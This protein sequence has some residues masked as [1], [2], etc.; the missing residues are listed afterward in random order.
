MAHNFL[1]RT[2]SSNREE[3]CEYRC[4]RYP[5]QGARVVCGLWRKGPPFFSFFFFFFLPVYFSVTLFFPCHFVCFES[6]RQNPG[7]GGGSCDGTESRIP[8]TGWSGTTSSVDEISRIFH[9]VGE[10]SFQPV[11]EMK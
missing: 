11:A 8:E 4:E 5:A 7:D 2:R 6:A 1:D 3:N 9:L 10:I